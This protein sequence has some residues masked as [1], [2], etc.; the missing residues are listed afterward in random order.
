MAQQN[1][2]ININLTFTEAEWEYYNK[3]AAKKNKSMWSYL[4]SEV[5]KSMSKIELDEGADCSTTLK[6]QKYSITFDPETE[7]KLAMAA[8]LMDMQ[9]SKFV[10]LIIRMP[11]LFSIINESANS[12]KQTPLTSAEKTR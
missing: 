11:H 2:R 1:N 5:T 3:E 4:Q 9:L 10:A 6:R 12:G 7:K 8:C